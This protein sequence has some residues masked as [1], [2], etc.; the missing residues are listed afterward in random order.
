MGDHRRPRSVFG[1]LKRAFWNDPARRSMTEQM[2]IIDDRLAQS[3]IDLAMRVAEV[4]LSIG[5]S[6]KEVTLAALRITTAYGLKS[7]HVN[8]TFN[9]VMLSDHRNGTGDPITLMQVVRSAA[10]DHA[11]LQRLQALVN[12]IESGQPLGD[13]IVDFHKIRRTPFMYRDAVVI[14]VQS[15]LGVAIALMY[16]AGWITLVLVF[17]AVL[18]VALT[19]YGLSR[20]RIPLFF[21]QAAGGFVLV[22]FAAGV[23]AGRAAGIEALVTV[24]P[25]VVVASGIVMMLAGLAVVGAAQDA[26]DG[27]SLTAGGRILDIAV[28]TMGLV[29]GIVTGLELARQIGYGLEMP[30]SLAFGPP[31]GHVAGAMLIAA[32]VAVL[33]GSG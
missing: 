16:G 9:S 8:V 6:A 22:A 3:I 20:L 27:F 29:V 13:A 17:V 15:L 11:K 7:V 19:Q 28:M 2:P 24:R 26:I 30:T 21:L 4:M 25:S 1:G 23:A 33:N 12:D 32:A 18:L 31:L 5:A 10:P 14:L